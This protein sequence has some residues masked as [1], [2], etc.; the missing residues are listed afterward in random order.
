MN[1]FT[2]KSF[3]TSVLAVVVGSAIF[4]VAND[5]FNKARTSVPKAV[6]ENV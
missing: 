4:T 6:K 1:I 3:W 2:D 5:Q